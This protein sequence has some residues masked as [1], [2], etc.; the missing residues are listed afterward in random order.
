[1]GIKSN[2]ILAAC[3]GQ[4]IHVNGV[5]N[6]LQLA[7]QWGYQTEFLSPPVPLSQFID[8]I[9]RNQ[10]EIVAVSYRL[11]PAIGQEVLSKFIEMVKQRKLDQRRFFLGC[12]PELAAYARTTEFFDA[13]FIGGESIEEVLPALRIT[14]S[15]DKKEEYPQSLVVRRQLKV[16]I[17]PNTSPFWIT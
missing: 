14:V 10:P 6:F 12:L 8:L 4:C 13:I 5:H 1:M 16:S 17:S 9:E 11:T 3:L 7:E 15:N 2:T